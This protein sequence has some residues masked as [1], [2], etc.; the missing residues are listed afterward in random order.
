MASTPL[1]RIIAGITAG[2]LLLTSV[3]ARADLDDHMQHMFSGMSANLTPPGTYST[4]RR[5]SISGGSLE[6]RTPVV[7]N[8]NVITFTPPSFSAGCNGISLHGGALSFV[9]MEQFQSTIKAI[10]ANGTGLVSGYAFKMALSA[11]CQS[12]AEELSKLMDTVN[13]V[14][15]GLKNSCE[16]A[17]GLAAAAQPSMDAIAGDVRNSLGIAATNGGGIS[18]SLGSVNSWLTSNVLDKVTPDAKKQKFG[19]VVYD[20]LDGKLGTWYTNGAGSVDVDLLQRTLMTM[21]GTVIIGTS[22]DGKDIAISRPP[23]KPALVARMLEGGQAS[24]YRCADDSSGKPCT[25]VSESAMDTKT[26]KGF[27]PQVQEMLLGTSTS[28]GIVAKLHLKGTNALSATEQAF[29]GAMQP[30][31][32]GLLELVSGSAGASGLVSDAVINIVS[33]QM[34]Y[35]YLSQ[36][37]SAVRGAVQGLDRPEAKE[38]VADLDR[39]I[40]SEIVPLR[41]QIDTEV[42]K[43]NNL[44]STQRT[45]TSMLRDSQPRPVASK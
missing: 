40:K 8:P 22:A 3:T 6:V 33:S 25:V 16:A 28:A 32:R 17:K 23:A 45:L 9:N 14:S 15:A 12:C 7:V 36:S 34:L 2:S 19:N 42:A 18:D 11:M 21:T 1:K 26:L 20:A 24:I 31:Y 37:L 39:L 5:G 10:A 43:L 29:L 4:A 27:R 30:N 41:Q 35:L 13:K 38:V 44:V